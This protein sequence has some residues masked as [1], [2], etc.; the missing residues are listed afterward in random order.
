MATPKTKKP[1]ITVHLSIP[2]SIHERWKRLAAQEQ[3]S[4][5]N[6]MLVRF[7]AFVE[8]EFSARKAA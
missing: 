4:L 6:W 2:R 8:K 1:D 5:R 7:G 3:R